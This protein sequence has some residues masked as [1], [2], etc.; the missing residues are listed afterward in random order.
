M[1]PWLVFT[2]NEARPFN[3]KPF[4]FLCCSMLQSSFPQQPLRAISDQRSN[5][6]ISKILT[7]RIRG[8]ADLY[9]TAVLDQDWS[10]LRKTLGSSN[11]ATK[12]LAS[13]AELDDRNFG[14]PTRN[15]KRVR[16]QYEFQRMLYPGC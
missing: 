15:F 7:S 1:P 4:N 12:R 16:A 5:N 8:S 3:L 2:F 14:A 13:D 9:A 10:P 6:L 11:M